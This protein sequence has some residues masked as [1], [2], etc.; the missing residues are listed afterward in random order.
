MAP[1][2]TAASVSKFLSEKFRRKPAGRANRFESGFRTFTHADG[3]V[4]VTA[5]MILGGAAAHCQL[6]D[7]MRT[8]LLQ[9]YE[10]E[11]KDGRLIVLRKLT[12]PSQR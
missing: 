6:M 9:R 3:R 11:A 1:G 5:R 8:H 10:V 2:I 7:Q 4:E 12:G